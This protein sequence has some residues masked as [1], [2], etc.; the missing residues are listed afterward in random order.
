[1]LAKKANERELAAQ[2]FI[3]VEAIER[4][5]LWTRDKFLY[6]FIRVRGHD[7]TL[8]E[9]DENEQVTEKLTI[10]LS[11]TKDPF[12]IISVPRTVD[13]QGMIQEL[14]ELRQATANEARLRLINGEI[15]ALEEL[16][17]EG[18]KEPLI[19]LKIWRQAT[20]NADKELLDCAAGLV[21]I[22]NDNQISASIMN[23]QQ[24]L[25]LCAIYA[26][27][28]IWQE[29]DIES[30]VPYLKGKQRRFT[31]RP[32]PDTQAHEELLEQITPVGGLFF[33]PD[34]FMV[35]STYCRCYGVTRYPSRIDYNWSVKLMNATDCIT[36]ITYIPGTSDMGDALSRSIKD[37]SREA[38]EERDTRKRKALERKTDDADKLIDDMDAK[39][40][41]L[42]FISVV[43]MPYGQS[44]EECEE[45][46]KSVIKR[47]SNKKMKIKLLTHS[48]REA[49]YH[50]S[51]YY[52]N[53][54]EIDSIV[55]RIFPL[56]TLVGGYPCTINTLRDDHGV[57]FA[58]TPDRGMIS[59][60]I[61][62]R[63]E[64]RTN[65]SGV[66]TG[67]PG[68]GKSTMLKH[69]LESMYMQGMR[70][71]VIDP[72]REFRELCKSLGGSWWDAGGGNAK[73]NLFQI[74]APFMDDEED[75]ALRS[76]NSPLSQH[77]QHIQTILQY[78]LPSLTDLHLALLARA[79]RALYQQ[80]DITLDW[81]FDPQRS[82]KD[83]PIMEDLY[84]YLQNHI[85]EDFRYEEL[86]LLVEDM[87]IGADSVIWNG[88]T[89]IDFANDFIVIDTNQLYNS[90][91]RNR[92]AQYYNLMRLAFSAASADRTTPHLIIADEAQTMFDPEL[93]QAAMGL[94]NIALRVRKYEGYLW[95]AFHSLHELLDPRVRLYGQ[96]ILDAATYKILFGTDGQ[97]LAD[98]AAL[99]HLTAAEQKVLD[100]RQRGRALALIGSQRLSVDFDIPQY[101]L[102][103][104]GKGG[105]R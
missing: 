2:E 11:E 23:D 8:L 42:G 34:Y 19:F 62:Y 86:A 4:N 56:E 103:L 41:S 74:Q 73:N 14:K 46:A 76:V 51:P 54:P 77:I 84:R 40:K 7:N 12:Q 38:R 90:T 24:I 60:D 70:S 63:G 36:S 47:Y 87:A 18:A 96:P 6:A 75:P 44:K 22:L 72:E 99:F 83:Y 49:Y 20:F 105:G 80:F 10:A 37:S 65:G 92:A 61:R 102:D 21:K 81:Q 79:L 16:A 101:K 5:I 45:N 59:L 69:L 53:Q 94:R 98:T 93:P 3:N 1:M 58:R 88:H 89:N 57:Y 95:L 78:K 28:G 71:I 30:D 27:L 26:E 43:T 82:P 17:A 13:T 35:G 91:D 50:L 104:M 67:K 39:D 9:D 66:T 15:D 55:Q 100:A 52:P 31:R 33:Q 64:D 25:H 97:N 29:S 32:D 48:Q 85:S 68:M